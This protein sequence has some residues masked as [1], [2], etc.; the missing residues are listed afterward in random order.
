[1]PINIYNRLV[2]PHFEFGSTIIVYTCSNDSELE[3]LQ[4][5]QN[6]E[7]RT[8]YNCY[9]RTSTRILLDKNFIHK[10]K[11]ANAPE[12]LCNQTKYVADVS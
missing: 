11:N 10:I 6:K 8:R 7:L 2:K 1:M 3:R 12:Y 9:T 5:L 4:K